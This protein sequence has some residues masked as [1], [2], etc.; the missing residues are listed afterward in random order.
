M[1]RT[2]AEIANQDQ[3]A[4]MAVAALT[5]IAG[6]GLA[7]QNRRLSSTLA[8]E[9]ERLRQSEEHHRY[10]VELSPHIAWL[11]DTG[12]RV[13]DVSPRWAEVIGTPV[14]KALGLAWKDFLH[15]DDLPLTTEHWLSV[16]TA[17]N[18]DGLDMRCRVRCVDGSYRWF[19]SHALPR[20]D[21]RGKL[22]KWY[23]TLE[24]IDDQVKAEL[25]LR[26][27]E[28]RYRL[29]SRA[30]NDVI[31]D[32]TI[33]ADHIEWSDAVDTVLGYPEAKGGTTSEWWVGMVHPSDQPRIVAQLKRTLKGAS[34][35]WSQELRLLTRSG[36]YLDMLSR[37]Y[38]VRDQA[39]KPVRL[40]GAL[41]DMTARKRSEDELRWAA[42]HDP[43]T[44]LPN[45]KLFEMRLATAL[46]GASEQG[47]SVGLM[48]LDVDGFKTLN[49]TH[50]HLAGDALLREL[51]GRL[52]RH[53]PS[54]ATVARL[55]GDELAI[56]L[57]SL[58]PEDARP[59][60][61]DAFLQ[62]MNAPLDYE[63]H[64]I[65]I[66]LSVGAAMF[67]HDG[68]NAEALLK[69]A[70]LALYAAK[71]EGGGKIRVF[72]SDLRE[73]AEREKTMFLESREALSDDRIVPFY[74]PKICLSS[75]AILGFEALLRWHHH[76]RGL[77]SPGSIGA[78]LEDRQ[79]AVQITDRMLDRTISDMVLWLE[80]GCDFKRIAVN[81][82]AEDFRAG[83]FAERILGRL[84]RSGVPPSCIE[85]EVTETVFLGK[86]ISQ[87]ER[88]LRTLREEGVTIA[89]DDFGTGYASLTHLQQF[90]VDIIKIDQ[91]F[92]SRMTLAD[93]DMIIIGALIDLAKNLGI[94]TVAE[95]VET[96]Q[97]AHLL[98]LRGCD[99][100]QGYFFERAIPA[101]RVPG[102]VNSAQVPFVTGRQAIDRVANVELKLGAAS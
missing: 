1:L 29:A 70:D 49:D 72:D 68:E 55:G 82:S 64:Q 51:A 6:L 17:G 84:A 18:D 42:T 44:Q 53:V 5:V 79:L 73:T 15:P 77:Q 99:A 8:A 92:V 93:E 13:T 38:V 47:V 57:P 101:S 52:T 41:L 20:R 100:A 12:G 46:D 23:G 76:R 10:S 69:S 71:A 74:Q 78:A 54:D 89:L 27:S 87:V 9:R 40:V 37:G 86:H 83:D 39:G 7:F 50:G 43:M 97:Q 25:A 56:I 61:L 36:Q 80:Q 102:F 48:V 26:A 32:W 14:D 30:T 59:Q 91:T 33:G 58:A 16:V 95:G 2:F 81:G 21:Q 62:K 63:H 94:G 67:P 11:A 60:R 28:E 34:D 88:T 24:D 31:W 4:L 45:R 96:Q 66:S 75:G 85:L 65:D 3:L 35:H 98:G 22:L 90:P 19:R